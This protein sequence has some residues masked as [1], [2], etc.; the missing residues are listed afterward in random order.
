MMITE[1]VDISEV[2]QNVLVDLGAQITMTSARVNITGGNHWWPADKAYFYSIF[3]NLLSNSLKY[4][5]GKT[6]E[7]FLLLK[8]YQ[9]DFCWS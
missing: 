7:I 3:Y 5:S 1:P 8:G 2:W 9:I 4:R 6:P